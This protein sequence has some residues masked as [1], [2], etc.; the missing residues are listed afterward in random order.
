MGEALYA[1]MFV[2]GVGS[3]IHCPVQETNPRS[4]L[5]KSLLM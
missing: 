1:V 2:F 5:D 3:G 4:M